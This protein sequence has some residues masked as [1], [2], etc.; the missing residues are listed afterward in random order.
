[1]NCY[2]FSVGL[3]LVNNFPK[4][5]CHIKICWFTHFCRQNLASRI[6]ALLSS[7]P[8]VC[9][10]W[11]GVGGQA[12]LIV[13]VTLPLHGLAFLLLFSA[14]LPLL[15]SLI[16][17]ISSETYGADLVTGQ[18]HRRCRDQHTYV[19]LVYGVFDRGLWCLRQMPQMQQEDPFH[20]VVSNCLSLS[21]AGR[22][23]TPY[24]GVSSGNWNAHN[25]TSWG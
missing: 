16:R 5:N 1:M 17:P 21:T 18:V 22:V 24:T 10:D 11:V 4:M 12:N 7:N 13:K 3:P 6:Y 15:N 25:W 9:Q 20:C 19:C 2:I 8:P 14:V 23:L